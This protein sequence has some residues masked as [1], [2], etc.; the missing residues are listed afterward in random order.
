MDNIV[1]GASLLAGRLVHH[2]RKL[3]IMWNDLSGWATGTGAG[4]GM[5]GRTNIF[6]VKLVLK[7]L[8]V[9][10]IYFVHFR[11]LINNH[12]ITQKEKYLEMAEFWDRSV[13]KWC[14]RLGL[15]ADVV[16][17]PVML[18]F[19]CEMLWTCFSLHL[20]H[21]WRHHTLVFPQ[22]S[23]TSQ[24]SSVP[25]PD[26]PVQTKSFTELASRRLTTF[27][28]SSN[29]VPDNLQKHDWWKMGKKASGII[30]SIES[31]IK[32]RWC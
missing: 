10:W 8:W 15:H 17:F 23:Q 13:R 27:L 16:E 4:G 24:V 28:V 3:I 22:F 26:S 9:I 29:H 32:H 1:F 20:L 12:T 6:M 31:M 5:K 2:N 11:I 25:T 18:S 19:L 14:L 7:I 30:K 21:L